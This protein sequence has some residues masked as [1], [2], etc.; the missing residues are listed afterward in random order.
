MLRLRCR[1]GAPGRQSTDLG[2]NKTTAAAVRLGYHPVVVVIDAHHPLLLGSASPRRRAL[3]QSVG[4]PLVVTTVDVDESTRTGE[5]PAD[6][7][8]RV[9]VAK[10]DAVRERH[11]RAVAGSREGDE[12]ASCAALLVADTV[13][14][15][16]DRL[17]GK[18]RDDAHAREMIAALVG[19]E[20]QVLTRFIVDSAGTD[21]CPTG[22]TVATSVWFRHVDDGQIDRYVATGEGRDKAGAYAIQGIGAL[23]V[24]RIAGSYANVVGL[25]LCAVVATLQ[26][27]GLVGPLPLTSSLTSLLA[28]SLGDPGSPG[29]EG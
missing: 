1:H 18:P 6:Y 4:L 7:L 28:S 11:D 12:L 21:G 19:A 22:E 10:H 16:G 3:L 27:L 17:M 8:R 9:V 15:Q 26:R 24:E 20:H 5:S 29:D 23:L 13:V 25:P 14:V 2:G